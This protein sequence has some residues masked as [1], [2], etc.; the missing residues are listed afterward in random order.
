M[1]IYNK[2]G[3]LNFELKENTL[4]I[5]KNGNE[6]KTINDIAHYVFENLVDVK[7]NYKSIDLD[8]YLYKNLKPNYYNNKLFIMKNKNSWKKYQLIS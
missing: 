8:Y 1:P 5:K 7:I 4:I 2:L 6:I 3:K